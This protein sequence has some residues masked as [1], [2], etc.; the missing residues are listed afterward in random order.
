M[1]AS[2]A[3]NKHNEIVDPMVLFLIFSVTDRRL[4]TAIVPVSGKTEDIVAHVFRCRD[5]E[6][7][8]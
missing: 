6:H 7:R 5:P 3:I 1:A 4:E 8:G 2:Q